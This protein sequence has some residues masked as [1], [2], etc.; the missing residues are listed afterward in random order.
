LRR[1]QILCLEPESGLSFEAA[2][3]ADGALCARKIPEITTLKVL[4]QACRARLRNHVEPY[5]TEERGRQSEALV[6]NGS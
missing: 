6:M 1:R 2:W 4:V 3:N 5:C